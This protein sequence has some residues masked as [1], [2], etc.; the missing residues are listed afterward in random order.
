MAQSGLRFVHQ[1]D[2]AASPLRSQ[3]ASVAH[4]H[5]GGVQVP[6]EHA[7]IGRVLRVG[8]VEGEG[9]GTCASQGG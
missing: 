8:H 1:P 7:R 3:A 4:R 5:I 6:V 9:V 2:G